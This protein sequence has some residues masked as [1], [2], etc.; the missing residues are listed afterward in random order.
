MRSQH[1]RSDELHANAGDADND[2]RN[3]AR[4]CLGRQLCRQNPAGRRGRARRRCPRASPRP[5]RSSAAQTVQGTE[6]GTTEP[7]HAERRLLRVADAL[8]PVPIRNETW[9]RGRPRGSPASTN[10][11]R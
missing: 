6:R 7:G 8:A 4:A 9:A 3:W 1:S 5:S 11:M 2:R 10:G